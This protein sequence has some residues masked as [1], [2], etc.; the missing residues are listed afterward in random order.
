MFHGQFLSVLASRQRSPKPR[1]ASGV[2]IASY[3][4]HRCV[5]T[6]GRQVPDRIATV[7]RELDADIVGL[8]EVDS[9]YHFRSGI[10]QVVHLASATQLEAVAGPTMSGE[11]GSYG[12]V[13]LTRRPVL[14][15]RRFDLSVGRRERRGALDVD[16]AVDG[17]TVRVIVTHFGLGPRERRAQTTALLRILDQDVRPLTVLLGDFNEWASARQTMHRLDSRF[18][19]SRPIRTFPSRWPALALDRIWVQPSAA[20][21]ALWAHRSRLSRIASDHL[22]LCAN[23]QWGED[24]DGIGR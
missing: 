7:I 9:R 23:L 16:V 18:G 2:R 19:S 3:N 5:G 8:Q 21:I 4:V 6:D 11:L 14:A 1:A 15:V 24:R 20:I 17:H 22:P 10:D 12:N 13:L